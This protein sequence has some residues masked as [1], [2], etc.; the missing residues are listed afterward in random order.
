MAG[1]ATIEGKE[2]GDCRYK[3]FHSD[4]RFRSAISREGTQDLPL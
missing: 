2:Q 4:E 1:G 3:T